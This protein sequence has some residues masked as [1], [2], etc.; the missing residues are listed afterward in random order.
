MTRCARCGASLRRD[1]EQCY[2]CEAPVEK[3]TDGPTLKDR[4]RLATKCM[5]FGALGL[6]IA[7]LFTDYVP[8]FWKCGAAAVIL[9]F[10]SSSA[11]Q[12]SE[13]NKS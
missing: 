10:V 3:K 6:T 13:G 5:F 8:S 9:H 2:T 1:E 11:D 7:S 4:F 12:M